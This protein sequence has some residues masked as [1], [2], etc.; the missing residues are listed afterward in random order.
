M[1]QVDEKKREHY[2]LPLV[3]RVFMYL[4]MSTGY[5]ETKKRLACRTS[6]KLE[7][8]EPEN[9]NALHISIE[10]GWQKRE[11]ERLV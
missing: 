10:K 8:M 7:K 3:T 1:T 2:I 11:S 6:Q 5:K 9:N 4:S